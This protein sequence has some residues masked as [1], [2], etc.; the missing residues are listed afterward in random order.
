MCGLFVLYHPNGLR[1][2]TADQ[3]RRALRRLSRRGPDD[4]GVFEDQHVFMGH[5]RL[6]IMDLSDNGAQPALGKDGLVLCFNGQIYN[7][8]PVKA[9]LQSMGCVFKS[10]CDTEV[11]LRAYEIW[12]EDAFSRLRGMWSVVIWEPKH[13][14]LVVSRDRMGQKPLF[15]YRQADGTMIFAS[16]IKSI[17][18]YLETNLLPNLLSLYRFVARGWTDFSAYSFYDDI[19]SV[20]PSTILKYNRS[21][22][23]QETNYWALEVRTNADA[24]TQNTFDI[25]VETVAQHLQSDAPIA[26]AL[27]GGI[28]STSIVSIVANVLGI[29]NKITGL[30][31][32]PPETPDESPWINSTV[33]TLGI[34]HAYVAAD[35]LDYR[36]EIDEMLDAHDEPIPKINHLYQGML[37]RQAG[38]MGFKVLLAGEAADEIFGGYRAFAPMYLAALRD[39][40]DH[41]GAQRFCDGAKPMTGQT[42]EALNT[43]ADSFLS[44]GN[45]RR[46]VQRE[47]FGYDVMTDALSFSEAEAFPEFAYP[48]LDARDDHPYLLREMRERFSLDIPQVLRIEDRNGM[49]RGVEVRSPFVDHVL[50]EHAY[51]FPQAAFMADGINKRPLRDAML[52]CIPTLISETKSKLRRPGNESFAVYGPLR[53]AISE[54]L[55]S[56]EFLEIGVFR[57]NLATRFA[58]SCATSSKTEAFVWFRVYMAGQWLRRFA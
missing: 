39:N 41:D 24:D 2:N 19:E 43:D 5:R 57:E 26:V 58:Q 36:H 3:A 10:T 12:G 4:E 55:E 7:Q 6:S 25:L 27:S 32:V 20:R 31:I 17:L 48:E 49:R 34:S 35:K 11:L 14:R 42:I 15:R 54:T 1:R 28:D 33:E 56:K 29:G 38:E 30:S 23:A 44:S 45:G 47:R 50:V 37:R 16:E 8:K 46:V 13:Q 21:G 53:D 9:E 18:T 22:E 52:G 51:S 40:G